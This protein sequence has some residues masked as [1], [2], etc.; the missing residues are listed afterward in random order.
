MRDGAWFDNPIA[1]FY[2]PAKRQQNISRPGVSLEFPQ[3]LEY[4]NL[5][6]MRSGDAPFKEPNEE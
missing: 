4:Q 6:L 1:H 3:T 5:I 2:F